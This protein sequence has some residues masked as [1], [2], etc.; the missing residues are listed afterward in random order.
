MNGDDHN[1]A[2]PKAGALLMRVPGRARSRKQVLKEFEEGVEELK[3]RYE[4][5]FWPFFVP[6]AEDMHRWRVQLECG[7]VHERY[8]RGVDNYPDDSAW[9]DPLMRHR[10][11]VGEGWCPNDH[12]DVE[13]AYRHVVE[14]IDSHVW[15]FPA[16]PEESPYEGIDAE[17]WAKIRKPEPHSSEFWRVRLSCGH[18]H[19]SVVTDVGWSPADG[20]RLSTE[21]R[22]AE[23]RSEFE[24]MW[25]AG[26]PTAWPEDE[27]ERNHLRRMLELRW[28]QPEPEQECRTCRNARRITGY[29]RIGWL[30]PR[31]DS[32]EAKADAER[33][34]MEARLAK[35]DAEARRLRELLGLASDE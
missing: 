15:E 31:T 25:S 33:R 14:W 18:V 22:A 26:G 29:Q 10:L 27:L 30:I 34:K 5:V 28:P 20:P 11:P 35:V 13:V 24:D 32:T 16:D 19:D 3:R 9:I 4:P 2:S 8:T 7:C 23:M 17:T 21:E 1:E 12:D 6:T